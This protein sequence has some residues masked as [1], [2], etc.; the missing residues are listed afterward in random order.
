MRRSFGTALALAACVCA[1][2]ADDTADKVAAQKQVA[3]AAWAAIE[4]G[5]AAH[6][7]TKHLLVYA[8]KEMEK[9]LKDVGALLEKQHDLAVAAL[10]FEKDADVYPGKLTVHL[11]ASRE[12]FTAFVRRVERRRLEPEETASHAANDEFLHAAA[13][14]PRGKTE[15]GAE[16]QAGAEL[17]ALLLRRKAGLKTE[18]PGWLISGFGRATHLRT[19]AGSKATQ[20]ER[21][22]AAALAR[23]RGVKAIYGS[24]AEAEEAPILQASL[25]DY[26]AYGGGSAKFPALVL[27]FRPAENV[28]RVTTEAALEAAGLGWERVEA[29]WKRAAA[30]R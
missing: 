23:I 6:V 15:P 8:P 10:G 28:V 2:R 9:R 12:Q 4:A 17:T 11:F 26:L 13:G 21:K 29:G 5:P 7:E 14:P 24:M 27:A 18:L 16:A 22:K 1:V 3:E 30:G 25:A 20:D 19:V